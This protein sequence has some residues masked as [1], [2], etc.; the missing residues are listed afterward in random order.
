[1]VN[2]VV[3]P[4]SDFPLGS[5]RQVT[6]QNRK[7]AIFHSAT[8]FHALRDSCPHQGAAL[9]TGTL[10]GSLEAPQPGCYQHHPEQEF[11]R[12][13]WHGWEYELATGRSWFDPQHN[14]VANYETSVVPAGELSELEDVRSPLVEGAFTAESFAVFVEDD[15]VVVQL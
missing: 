1:M 3:G 12:C 15:Y 5:T 14:R 6:A 8:G 13:P 7:I 9:S 10:V 11:I 4:V 2:V